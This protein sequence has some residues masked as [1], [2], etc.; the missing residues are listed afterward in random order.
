[1]IENLLQNIASMARRQLRRPR[2]SGARR[3]ALASLS[4]KTP[5]DWR[6]GGHWQG[7]SE[8]TTHR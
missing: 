1:M 4:T 6:L 2:L 5:Q 3:G 8:A 7:T